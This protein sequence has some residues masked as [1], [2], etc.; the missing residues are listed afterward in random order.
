MIRTKKVPLYILIDPDGKILAK[1]NRL[2]DIE[3]KL[4][5]IR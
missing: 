1:T 3:I 4:D 5:E 2:S